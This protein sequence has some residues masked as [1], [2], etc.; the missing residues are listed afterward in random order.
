MK[1]ISTWG[2]FT[3]IDGNQPFYFL[4][5]STTCPISQSAFE[6]VEH[7]SEDHPNSP[8]YFLNV[9]DSRELSNRI[10]EHFKVK[11]ESPQ[12]FLISNDQVLHHDSHWKI[13]YSALEE[14]NQKMNSST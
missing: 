5:N 12:L 11:H 3:S 8:V 14:I 9:Q 10:A 1:K 4:K 7:F 6:E 13:T 2:E